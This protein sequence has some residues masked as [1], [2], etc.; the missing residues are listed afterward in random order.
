MEKNNQHKLGSFRTAMQKKKE[1]FFSDFRHCIAINKRSLFFN[2]VKSMNY[3]KLNRVPKDEKNNLIWFLRNTGFYDHERGFVKGIKG[4]IRQKIEFITSPSINPYSKSTM[5]EMFD[6][7]GQLHPKE[8]TGITLQ[9]YYPTERLYNSLLDFFNKG[10]IPVNVSE[11]EFTWDFFTENVENFHWF[12]NHHIF[13][14]YNRSIPVN[15]ETTYYLQE[16]RCGN[17]MRTYPKYNLQNGLNN[18][19]PVRLEVVFNRNKINNLDI[20]LDNLV[21]KINDFDFQKVFTF[22]EFDREKYINLTVERHR[23]LIKQKEKRDLSTRKLQLYR[24]TVDSWVSLIE[25]DGEELEKLPIAKLSAKLK[26]AD[27]KGYTYKFF[28]E[29]TEFNNE[30]FPIINGGGFL[31]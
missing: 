28:K 10:Y 30:I 21:E 9:I 15:I 3:I 14:K 13:K 1:A 25:S 26:Q 22:K 18:K 17:R 29:L 2:L 20:E 4:K 7:L 5:I 12:L 11:V 24:C 8:D 16:A 19:Y 31:L 6:Y 27:P 23:R